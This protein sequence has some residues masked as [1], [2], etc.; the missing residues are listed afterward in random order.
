MDEDVLL[1]FLRSLFPL[2]TFSRDAHGTWKATGR[3]LISSSTIDGLL[4]CLA[5][6]DPTAFDRALALLDTAA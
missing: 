3:I 6:A 4:D 2:W 1:L 5:T